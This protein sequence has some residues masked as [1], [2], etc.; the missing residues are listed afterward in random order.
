MVAAAQTKDHENERLWNQV[1]QV[2]GR[3][4]VVVVPTCENHSRKCLAAVGCKRMTCRGQGR[5]S[6]GVRGCFLSLQL[7]GRRGLEQACLYACSMHGDC[8]QSAQSESLHPGHTSDGTVFR[9]SSDRLPL[10]PA[11]R[12]PDPLDPLLLPAR[13][14]TRPSVSSRRGRPSSASWR[15]G[16]RRRPSRR[17]RRR[18]RCGR[19][20]A[21]RWGWGSGWARG[22]EWG[23][24][25][26][27]C[28][29]PG[30]GS[31]TW[32]ATKYSVCC[33]KLQHRWQHVAR[34]LPR[35]PHL[36]SP[37]CI[38]AC[39]QVAAVRA[40]LQRQLGE[41]QALA[42]SRAAAIKDM[43]GK[44]QHLSARV[45]TLLLATCVLYWGPAFSV[46]LEG[47][48]AVACC[49]PFSV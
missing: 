33:L 16:W 42:E 8:L 4:G 17:R 3:V 12:R 43:Q 39:L 5:G 49:R 28:Q 46:V 37:H 9:Q 11:W 36:R 29:L 22:E 44:I 18:R 45:S 2:R 47:N 13:P 31:T 27:L 14:Q 26:K 32:S 35:N 15:V 30:G 34:W 7:S 41:A 38:R 48:K 6:A 40:E 24:A 25:L 10:S 23:A 20:R 1:K 21:R 19:R